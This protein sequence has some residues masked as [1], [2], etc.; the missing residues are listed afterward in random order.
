M[1]LQFSFSSGAPGKAAWPSLTRE[2]EHRPLCIS[3]GRILEP[4][5]GKQWPTVLGFHN[6]TLD[7]PEP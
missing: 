7:F 6:S 4:Y 2:G 3:K 1:L 5:Q